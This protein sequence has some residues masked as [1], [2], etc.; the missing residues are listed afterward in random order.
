MEALYQLSYS[1][2]SLRDDTDRSGPITTVTACESGQPA[3][4]AGPS[5]QSILGT[6]V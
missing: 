3:A 1:P 2:E 6:S 4:S 5:P